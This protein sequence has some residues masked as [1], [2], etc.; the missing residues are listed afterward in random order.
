MHLL[1]Y[2]GDYGPELP[3]CEGYHLLGSNYKELHL[4]GCDT[5]YT[6]K[7]KLPTFLE[8]CCLHVYGRRQ[9]QQQVPHQNVG[10]FLQDCLMSHCRRRYS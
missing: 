8:T 3:R 10:N 1:F 7:K 4:L 5:M 9:W 2:V 6:G